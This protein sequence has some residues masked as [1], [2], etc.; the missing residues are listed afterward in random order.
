VAKLLLAVLVCL[1]AFAQTYRV[2]APEGVDRVE[3][4]AAAPGWDVEVTYDSETCE[5]LC[6]Y[7][8]SRDVLG[9]MPLLPPP[10]KVRLFVGPLEPTM[11]VVDPA[12]VES[13]VLSDVPAHL[14]DESCMAVKR[15]DRQP[16]VAVASVPIQHHTAKTTLL[17]RAPRIT[18][19]RI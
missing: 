7:R 11:V 16:D 12:G 13:P 3:W 2:R 9:R 19:L 10:T 17:S 18:T 8:R 6:I 14:A 4:S 15:P 1:P 5:V